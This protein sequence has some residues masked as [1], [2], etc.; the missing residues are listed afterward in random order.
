MSIIGTFGTCS[1]SNYN[2]LTDLIK[3][4]ESTKTEELIKE[5]YS[6]V[7]NSAVKLENDKCSGEVFSALLHYLN[8]AYGVDVRCGIEGIGEKWRDVTGDF[9]IIVF[10]E[11]ERILALEDT[12]DYDGLFQFINDFFQIDYADAGQIAW[13]VL[14]N[15][16]K[17]IEAE[18]IL[19]LHLF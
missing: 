9:D 14:L 7:E 3:S 19:I 13:N 5:I 17:S 11:K 10:H 12:I 1:K 6:E 15:N 4:G 16:L 8:T 2:E 18:N